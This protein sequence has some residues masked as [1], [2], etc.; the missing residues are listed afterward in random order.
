[1]RLTRAALL[2]IG[3]TAASAAAAPAQTVSI[4][5]DAIYEMPGPVYASALPIYATPEITL[6]Q[7]ANFL[8]SCFCWTGFVEPLPCP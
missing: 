4:A 1:M 7:P 6:A 3:I 2:G 8:V 5:L